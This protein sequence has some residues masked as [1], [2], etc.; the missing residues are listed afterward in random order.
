MRPNHKPAAQHRP[1]ATTPVEP[2]FVVRDPV[3][4][5]ICWTIIQLR[6]VSRLREFQLE[7]DGRVFFN[8]KVY[9]IAK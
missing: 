3:A 6:E 1:Q 9:E 2:G 5:D 8:E 7:R 4:D